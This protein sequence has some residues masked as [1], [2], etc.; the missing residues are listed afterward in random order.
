[1]GSIEKKVGNKLGSG[2]GVQWENKTDRLGGEVGGCGWGGVTWERF[3][4]KLRG[5][6][7]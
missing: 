3:G 5:L 7:S 2:W 4:G 6:E 1:M